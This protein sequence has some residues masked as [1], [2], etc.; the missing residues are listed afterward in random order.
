MMM[1]NSDYFVN[2]VSV[3]SEFVGEDMIQIRLCICRRENRI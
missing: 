3:K 1:V 2:R